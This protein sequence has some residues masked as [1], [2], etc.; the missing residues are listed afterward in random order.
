MKK[1]SSSSSFRGRDPRGRPTGPRLNE[2]IRAR[3]IRVIDADGGQLG[4]MTPELALR[5]AQ[6]KGFDLVEI[7]PDAIP[8][9]CKIL[10]YGK[11]KYEQKKKANDAKKRQVVVALK[12]VKFRVKIED[13]DFEFKVRNLRHFLE[14]GNKGKITIMFRGREITHPELG[15]QILER[16]KVKIADLAV[17]EMEPRLEGRNMIMLV[18]PK[19]Q[20][21]QEKRRLEA[22]KLKAA[23]AAAAR[24]ETVAPQPEPAGPMPD[25][26]DDL[27]HEDLDAEDAA[28]GTA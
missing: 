13:H 22:E 10:D 26:D 25:P 28:E 11:F 9:V 1:P 18:A 19:P 20:V 2:R 4:V 6:E 23:E 27:T 7:S 5:I 14:D 16:V 21:L 24:G 8:P 15:R 17:I 12:E 3:E